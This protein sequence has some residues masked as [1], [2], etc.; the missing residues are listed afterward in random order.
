MPE[1]RESGNPGH[2]TLREV[3]TGGSLSLEGFAI[4][5]SIRTIS[6]EDSRLGSVAPL[7]MQTETR[8]IQSKV[9]GTHHN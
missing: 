1:G 2:D 7:Q 6:G 3:R 5:P 4:G 8:E 9:V